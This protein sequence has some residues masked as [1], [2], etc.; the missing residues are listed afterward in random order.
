[1]VI[2]DRLLGVGDLAL[3]SRMALMVLGTAPGREDRDL[4][5]LFQSSQGMPTTGL[6]TPDV[7]YQL[8]ARY[9]IV[10]PKPRVWGRTKQDKARYRAA[11]LDFAAKDRQR[12]EEWRKA[13]D[14]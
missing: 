3:A 2:A 1:M 14:V 12:A 6:Y 9:G 11:M 10:P 5:R 13:A 7:A 4:V 8:A